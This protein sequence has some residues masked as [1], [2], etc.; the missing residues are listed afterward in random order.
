MELN[1]PPH[2][3]IAVKE[4][5]QA[6]LQCGQVLDIVLGLVGSISDLSWAH[7]GEAPNSVKCLLDKLHARHAGNWLNRGWH[8]PW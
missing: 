5:L 2:L 7:R 6:F 4:G 3:H 1:A 8:G